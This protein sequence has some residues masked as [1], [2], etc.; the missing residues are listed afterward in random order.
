[1]LPIDA[2]SQTEIDPITTARIVLPY[3]YLNPK[4]APSVKIEPGINKTVHIIYKKLSPKG[5]ANG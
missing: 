3:A 1:M 4:P 2:P 5:P